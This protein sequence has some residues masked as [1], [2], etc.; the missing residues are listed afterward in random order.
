[1]H[2]LLCLPACLLC[3]LLGCTSSSQPAQALVPTPASV[4]LR[5]ASASYPPYVDTA[6]H[7]RAALDLVS[8]ALARAGYIAKNEIVPLDTVLEGLRADK[9]DGSAA[10]W[11]SEEREQFL[12][13]SDTLLENRLLLV[14]RLG[15]DVSATTLSA[16]QG[17]KVGV[18]SDYAYGPELDQAKE[19]VFVRGTSTEDNLRSLLRGELDYVI[20]DALV[21]HHL[22]QQFPQQTREKL[23]TGTTPLIKRTLHFA[24]R[25]SFPGAAGIIENFNR[26]L[27]QMLA[28][29]SYNDALHVDWIHADIDNDGTPELVAVGDHIGADPPGSGYRPMGPEGGASPSR[30][31]VKGVAYDSWQA[32]PDEYKNPSSGHSDKPGTLRASVFEF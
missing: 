4:Q 23:A 25:K 2:K 28:D 15:S 13:Y 29:G 3:L 26:Q 30:F 20:A 8:T 24:V 1:V 12:L 16:L 19:P 18:V 14:A 5:L 9:Y 27:A 32:V 17:K 7:P 11:R 10:L 22:A 21:V 31:V 6:D